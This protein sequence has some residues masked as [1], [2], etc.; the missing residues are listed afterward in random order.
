MGCNQSQHRK[1]KGAL[2]GRNLHTS[3]TQNKIREALK[4]KLEIDG[5][6][7]K[8][9]TLERIILKFEKN[10][11]HMKDIKVLFNELS[12]DQKSL[13]LDGLFEA[14]NLLHGNVS[15]E[16]LKELFEYVDVD[17][18][19]EIS[20][21]EFLC[22]LTVALVLKIIPA[23]NQENKSG[24]SP[25]R[26]AISFMHGKNNEIKDML[27]LIVSAYLR[28]DPECEGKI[29]ATKFGKVLEENA[30]VN[31]KAASG[32]GNHN[33][34]NT[35]WKEMDFDDNGCIDFAEFVYSFSKWVDIDDDM[36][37]T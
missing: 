3:K 21:K 35:K 8:L 24:N 10:R 20:L 6:S 18:S 23:F 13:N 9:L 34:S 27:E 29:N 22:L 36:E 33:V 31:H 11:S 26:A 25:I 28:F 5:D 4:V 19:H 30:Q 7:H 37:Q 12:H 16:E 1:S 32:K 15:K 17:E 14:M 2:S